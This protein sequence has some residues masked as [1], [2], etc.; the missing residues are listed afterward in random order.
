MLERTRG[1]PLFQE[2]L[3]AMAVALGDCT[4]DDADLLR[5]AMGSKRGVE[6]IESIKEK[7][8]AGMAAPR[9][10]RRPGR[11][12]LRQ[13]PVLRQLRLRRVATRCRFALLVYA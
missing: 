12:D 6:R 9:P 5:R 10:H 1:V 3:M 11:R 8:Y 2:Q 13:D 4:R 7:L